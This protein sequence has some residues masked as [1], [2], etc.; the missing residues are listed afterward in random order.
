MCCGSAS[1]NSSRANMIRSMVFVRF[2]A[3]RSLPLSVKWLHT[4]SAFS[5][6]T[7]TV[8]EDNKKLKLL[9]E[10]EPERRFHGIWLRHNCRCPECTSTY[11]NQTIVDPRLLVPSLRVESANVEGG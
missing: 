9:C 2:A 6:H 11:Y 7:V 4:S 3:S 1:A 10:N 5:A 8:S